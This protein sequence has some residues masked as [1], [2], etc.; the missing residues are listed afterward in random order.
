M[1]VLTNSFGGYNVTVQ[2]GSDALLPASAGN[3]D[4]IPIALLGVRANDTKPYAP[5]TDLA[6][7]VVA[8]QNGPTSTQG[9]GGEQ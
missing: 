9:D 1:T 2:A 4:R 5:L 6:A 3:A 7:H 8:R